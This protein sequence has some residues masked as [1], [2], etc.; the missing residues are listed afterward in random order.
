MASSISMGAVNV[1]LAEHAL[2]ELK[3]RDREHYTKVTSEHVFEIQGLKR[4][5]EELKHIYQGQIYLL[6]TIGT[7]QQQVND[8]LHRNIVAPLQL[9]NQQLK[10]QLYVE[11]ARLQIGI[12]EKEDTIADLV[13]QF[14]EHYERQ[15][16]V[17]RSRLQAQFNAEVERQVQRQLRQR[18]LPQPAQL[19]QNAQELNAQLAART[20]ELRVMTHDRDSQRHEAGVQRAECNGLR[21][22]YDDLFARI[23][24]HDQ[25]YICTPR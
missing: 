7:K 10:Q 11:Q 15:I 17:E 6:D 22:A 2:S 23:T 20:E 13:L 19:E 8:E 1:Q 24:A 3:R 14:E 21:T 4:Q 18:P 5:L 9:D 12:K 25:S 16:Q